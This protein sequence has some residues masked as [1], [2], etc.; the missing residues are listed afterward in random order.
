MIQAAK[1]AS[2]DLLNPLVPRA[3]NNECQ[4]PLF[5]LHIK[6]VKVS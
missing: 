2:T 4:N 3:H 5:P 6:P 1:A